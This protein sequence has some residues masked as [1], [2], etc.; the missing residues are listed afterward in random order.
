MQVLEVVD[1]QGRRRQVPLDRPR[2][3]IGRDR[4]AENVGGDPC[5]ARGGMGVRRADREPFSS[6]P[7]A[8]LE[9]CLQGAGR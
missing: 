3:L 2:L 1:G 8:L 5:Q 9:P 7:R 4:L 6:D